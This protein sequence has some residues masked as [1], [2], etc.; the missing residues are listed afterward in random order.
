MA[1][2]QYRNLLDQTALVTGA[3]SGIGREIAV[4]LAGDGAEVI[5][6][7]R[8]ATR[9]AETVDRIATRSSPAA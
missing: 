1:A 4:R 5:V 2:N 8:N 7:G 3:T 6:H 9:G